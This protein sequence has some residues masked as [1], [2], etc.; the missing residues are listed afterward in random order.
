MKN[1]ASSKSFS[2]LRTVGI[3]VYIIDPPNLC[4]HQLYRETNLAN[5][6]KPVMC[7]FPVRRSYALQGVPKGP[8]ERQK[9]RSQAAV[10]YISICL[11][12]VYT[13]DAGVLWGRHEI[14]ATHCRSRHVIRRHGATE[15]DC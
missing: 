6:C 15:I 3:R 5:Q 13:D 11:S 10:I 4:H 8:T 1:F 14:E 2:G 12:K 7:V 9:T